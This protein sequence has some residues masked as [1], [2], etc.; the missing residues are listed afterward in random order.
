[1]SK[2]ISDYSLKELEAIQDHM[3][4]AGGFPS[5]VLAADRG[6]DVWLLQLYSDIENIIKEK[7]RPM[8]S[9]MQDYQED[10]FNLEIASSL[11]LLGYLASHDSWTNGHPDI[12]VESTKGFKWIGESKIHSSYE[13]LLEGFRQL[14]ERYSSGLDNENEGAVLIITKNSSIKTLMEKW[15]EK[16]ISD[17]YYYTNG[18]KAEDLDADKLFFRSIHPHSVSGTSFTVKHIPISILFN[19]TD[20]SGRNRKK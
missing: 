20:K 9:Y 14:C 18:I 19:P 6:Y 2:D 12:L 16:L 11:K 4:T 10:W 17:S 13:Y 15:R 5:R 7:I 1:M 8:A 3:P